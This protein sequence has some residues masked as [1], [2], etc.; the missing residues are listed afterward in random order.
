MARAPTVVAPRRRW[1]WRWRL[2][3]W[4][5]GV[6]RH[7]G[8]RLRRWRRRVDRIRLRCD[9]YVVR[10][11]HDRNPV[12]HARLHR[13]A[14]DLDHEAGGRRGVHQGQVV[15]A[16]FACAPAPGATLTSCTGTV[17]N[18]AAIGT[19]RPGSH[20]FAVTAEDQDGGHA[21]VTST[22]TGLILVLG[23]TTAGIAR[24]HTSRTGATTVSLR[25]ACTGPARAVCKDTARLTVVEHLVGRHVRSVSATGRRRTVTVGRAART[26]SSGQSRLVT[27]KLN[28]TGKRLLARFRRLKVR[29]RVTARRAKGRSKVVA[30][31]TLTLTA[32]AKHR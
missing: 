29:L 10:N 15:K 25:L 3:W 32:P 28:S 4:R 24:A 22:Y 23:T 27:V 12:G 13:A 1:R 5:W 7:A 26:L 20:T 9:R 18:R 2:R 14:L 6:R 17:A 31:Q 30:H 16:A 21:T 19:R 8:P 11:G